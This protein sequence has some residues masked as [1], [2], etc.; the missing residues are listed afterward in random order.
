MEHL[1][2]QPEECLYIGDGGSRELETAEEIGMK[3]VQAVWYLRKGTTQPVGR[4]DEFE[5]A[6]SPLEVLNFIVL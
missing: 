6:E 2:V 1:K 4:K 3:A 5:Q